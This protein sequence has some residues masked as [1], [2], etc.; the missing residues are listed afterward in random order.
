MSIKSIR[1]H[2]ASTEKSTSRTII[3]QRRFLDSSPN[4]MT[5]AVNNT[6]R[7]ITTKEMIISSM[8]DATKGNS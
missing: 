4:T 3:A 1:S 7:P 6:A 5:A 2:A 8:P